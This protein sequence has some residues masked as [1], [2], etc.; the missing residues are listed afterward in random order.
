MEHFFTFDP[1]VTLGSILEALALSIGGLS[2]IV[3]M[4]WQIRTIS[5]KQSDLDVQLHGIK[6]EIKK[7]G[8]VLISV[9][10]FDERLTSHDLRLNELSKRM[11]GLLEAKLHEQRSTR[12][13]S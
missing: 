7:I 5:Y 13:D 6:Q 3:S 4:R 8:E 9:A 1:T 11:Y 2:V 10:R 12:E